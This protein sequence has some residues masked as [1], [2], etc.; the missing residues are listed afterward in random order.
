MLYEV[1]T[2]I[3]DR[4]IG[5]SRLPVLQSVPVHEPETVPELDAD[6]SARIRAEGPGPVPV[7]RGD[8]EELRVVE[9]LR[10]LVENR[11]GHLHPASDV[12]GA[13]SGPDPVR[14]NFV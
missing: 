8:E 3:Q 10:D 11:M 14:N 13:V 9:H 5:V 1:I 4:E 12:D 6:P 7:G 2:G